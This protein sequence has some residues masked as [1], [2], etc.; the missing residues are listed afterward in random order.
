[1]YVSKRKFLL[2]QPLMP[3]VFGTDVNRDN[4]DEESV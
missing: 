1:M 2:F 3:K 4:D